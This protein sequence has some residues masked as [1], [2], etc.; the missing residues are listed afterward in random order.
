VPLGL[1]VNELAT[2]AF[3]HAFKG[4]RGGTLGIVAMRE[5]EGSLLVEV[6][7]DGP[8]LPEG[9]FNE[10][11]GFGLGLA[12]ML[13]EQLRGE[14]SLG[15]GPGARIILR[16]SPAPYDGIAGEFG[17]EGA[18]EMPVRAAMERE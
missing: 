2:N 5:A 3:K 4:A 15:Q 1:L 6:L 14:L 9:A 16:F 7:D 13:A 17:R 8:G 11:S 12:R 10:S 18:A